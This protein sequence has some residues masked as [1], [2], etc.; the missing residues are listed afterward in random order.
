MQDDR[1][2]Q[3]TSMPIAG[4][5]E[6][7]QKPGRITGEVLIR[8]IEIDD[9][10]QGLGDE[11]A[12]RARS[13]RSATDIVIDIELDDGTDLPGCRVGGCWGAGPGPIGT[14]WFSLGVP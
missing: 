11:L 3:Y 12:T 7:G 13:E 9:D 5:A 10:D 14:L 1:Q 6:M 8:F 4:S 2:Q